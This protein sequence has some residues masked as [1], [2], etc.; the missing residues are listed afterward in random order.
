M[1]YP[2]G[3]YPGVVSSVVAGGGGEKVWVEYPGEKEMFRVERHLLYATH[4]A[5]MT[6]WEL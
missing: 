6:H 5:A 4:A 2:N 3:V 1:P